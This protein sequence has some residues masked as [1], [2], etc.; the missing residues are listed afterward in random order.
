[1]N[2]DNKDGVRPFDV[3][4]QARETRIARSNVSE[5]KAVQAAA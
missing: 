4:I 5:S 3:R 1:V 2:N